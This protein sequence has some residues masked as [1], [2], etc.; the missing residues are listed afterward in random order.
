MLKLFY[1]ISIACF[2]FTW[3]NAQDT[4][5]SKSI[6]EVKII[7]TWAQER[8]PVTHK[9]IKTKNLATDNAQD[10]PM[11][12]SSQVSAVSSTDAGNGTGYT[13]LRIRGSD[14]TRL[15]VTLDGVPVNDAE[16]QNVFWVDLPD[17]L[18]DAGSI[19]IQRGL[20]LSSAGP[21]AFGGNINLQTG[22]PATEFSVKSNVGYGSF[23]TSKINLTVESGQIGKFKFKVRG[24]NIKSNGYIDRASSNLQAASFQSHLQLNKLSIQAN[25]YWGKEKTY[26]AWYGVPYYYF[27]GADLT[28]KTYNPAGEISEG[29]FYD[30]ESD[31]YKQ[32]YSR[33]ILKKPIKEN[34]LLSVTL[35]HTYGTGYYNQYKPDADISE[36]FN[37]YSSEYGDLIRERWLRNNLFGLNAN[38]NISTGNMEHLVGLN[39]QNYSGKHFGI[40]SSFDRIPNWVRREYY[41]NNAYKNEQSFFYKNELKYQKFSFMIDLQVRNLSYTYLGFLQNGQSGSVNEKLFF[42]N[43]KAGVSYQIYKNLKT[44]LYTGYGHKE[45]N[46]DDYTD[47]PFNKKPIAEKLLNTEAGILFAHNSLTLQINYFLMHYKDQLVVSGQ[48]NDVGAYTRINA[49]KSFRTGIE[50]DLSYSPISFLRFSGNLSWSKNKIKSIDEYID[51]SDFV[52]GELIYLPQR[53]I[54]HSNTDISFSPDLIAFCEVSIKPFV[55]IDNLL[56]GLEIIYQSKFVSKQ[57]MDNFEN[58]YSRLPAFTKHG[59][60][61][62]LPINIKKHKLI[63]STSVNNLFNNIIIPNGW[64][65]RY[66]YGGPASDISS[67]YDRSEGN[68]LFTQSGLFPEATR[69]YFLNIN[70]KF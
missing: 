48:L 34:S 57:Y 37:Q 7:G 49:P 32:I 3:S 26:Q 4:L 67:A 28:K 13:Y 12:L 8:T 5:Q 41:T 53:I 40:V 45:P 25:V 23:N 27:Y 47:A 31:N 18:E 70:Y 66:Y 69:N 22:L 68:G 14:Q 35:Y 52:N 19:Q 39:V 65:Y 56:S 38:W 46:R 24:S 62:S 54:S 2:L 43:P 42:L 60:R 21:G 59:L 61:L 29:K 1:T 50:L 17:M 16:S 36:Y 11:L 30:D 15:N 6:G 33:I 10:I 9:T 55:K 63:I 58:Y 64:V 51:A 44:Y 20:G